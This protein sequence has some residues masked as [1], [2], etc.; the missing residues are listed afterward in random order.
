[1]ANQSLI[2]AAQRMYSAKAQKT[3]LTPIVQGAASSIANI[4]NA[5]AEKRNR[6]E[7]ESV[8]KVQKPFIEVVRDNPNV[9]A[10]L[11]SLLEEQQ[12][13]YFEQQKLAEGVFRSRKTKE[14]AR[15]ELKKIEDNIINLN[16]SLSGVD[17]KQNLVPRNKVSKGN[18]ATAQVMDVTFNDKEALAQ[19]IIIKKD[20]KGNLIPYIKGTEYEEGKEGGLIALDD[21]KA[22]IQV[23]QAGFDALTKISDKLTGFGLKGVDFEASGEEGNIR[24]EVAK[25]LDDQNAMSL[26]F[27]D[28]EGF[29]WAQNQLLDPKEGFENPGVERVDGVIRVTN[30]K[31]YQDNLETLRKR[32]SKGKN[33]DENTGEVIIDYAKELE[34]DLIASFKMVNQKAL[35]DYEERKQKEQDEFNRRNPREPR[36]FNTAVGHLS[37]DEVRG[38]FDDIKNGYVK[39]YKFTYKKFGDKFYKVDQ[40]EN[41]LRED[42]EGITERQMLSILRISGHASKFGFE[43]SDSG[44]SKYKFGDDD[45]DGVPNFLDDTSDKKNV[46]QI[47]DVAARQDNTL[48]NK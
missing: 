29:N 31:V 34:D 4:M 46:L 33:I 19:N 42:S 26:Y 8:E 1:M 5:V 48:L 14:E 10:Q 25:Q 32:V 17:L 36:P 44:L 38:L 37:E 18:S 12:E 39:D 28:F 27:D 6:Q 15:A 40:D 16:K 35:Q 47:G 9:G 22:A 2:Q 24:A 30:E 43:S 41:K 13:E 45:N 20:E 23:H 11:T 21:Y 3:D 7:K